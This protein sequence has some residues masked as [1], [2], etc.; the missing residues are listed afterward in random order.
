MVNYETKPK[1]HV[2]HNTQLSQ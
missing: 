1:K 2:L